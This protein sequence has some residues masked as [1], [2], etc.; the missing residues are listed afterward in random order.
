MYGGMTSYSDM[1]RYA[2]SGDGTLRPRSLPQMAT[3]AARQEIVGTWYLLREGLALGRTGWWFERLVKAPSAAVRTMAVLA[4]LL[5]A[6][7]TLAGA[8]MDWRRHPA[9]LHVALALT[10]MIAA[11]L[12]ASA[13]ALPRY[14]MPFGVFLSYFFLLGVRRSLER[15][16]RW[17]AARATWATAALGAVL[18]TFNLAFAGRHIFNLH[19]PGAPRGTYYATVDERREAYRWIEG[20]VGPD[21]LV[22]AH[23]AGEVYLVTGRH[24]EPF[25][26]GSI[27]D[28]H[29]DGVRWVL[30][31]VDDLEDASAALAAVGATERWR[32]QGARFRIYAV[33]PG[34]GGL[35]GRPNSHATSTPSR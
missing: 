33:A 29:G 20:H 23:Y 1:Y 3:A 30:A 22:A 34:P 12:P 13:S 8:A 24:A 35:R 16:A 19:G 32:S 21:E 26:T 2:A 5:A 4:G 10:W 11:T 31:G 9:P 14:V 7:L 28:L 6:A 17:P 25:V 15:L 18:V 27:P